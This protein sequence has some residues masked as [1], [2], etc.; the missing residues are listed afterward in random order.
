MD[1]VTEDNKKGTCYAELHD[2][3]LIRR[4]IKTFDDV[5]VVFRDIDDGIP[6][7]RMAFLVAAR[8]CGREND[9]LKVVKAVA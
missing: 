5:Y 6:N 3:L 7:P 9:R 8:S 1:D 2:A 4:A